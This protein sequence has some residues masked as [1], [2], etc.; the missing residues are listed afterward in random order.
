MSWRQDL[1]AMGA[2]AIAPVLPAGQVF[3]ART[4][5]LALG[6]A[7]TAALVNTPSETKDSLSLAAPQFRLVTHLVI[8]LRLTAASEAA[9]EAQIEALAAAVEGAVL[10]D[11]PLMAAVEQVASIET[12]LVVTPE[13]KIYVGAASLLF[14]CQTYWEPDLPPSLPL[15]EIDV[16][17]LPGTAGPTIHVRP[18]QS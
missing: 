10:T 18:P 13:A 6:A 17:P 9:A 3:E 8:D 16:V 2:A 7:A 5:P 4:W 12:Q 11:A 15:T 14:A 1:R